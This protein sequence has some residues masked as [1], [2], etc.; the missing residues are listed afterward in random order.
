MEVLSPQERG[1]REEGLAGV[2]LHQGLT[3]GRFHRDAPERELHHR[4]GP[5]LR[6]EL[7][8]SKTCVCESLSPSLKG[9]WE[10]LNLLDEVS[11]F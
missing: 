11:P 3:W 9:G 2:W 10:K 6:Q 8:F 4:A 5:P 1:M 7:W